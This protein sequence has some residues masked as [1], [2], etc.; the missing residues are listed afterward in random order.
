MSSLFI[1]HSE[2]FGE[3]VMLTESRPLFRNI[4]RN[5]CGQTQKLAE[6]S[7]LL[8]NATPVTSYIFPLA[9]SIHTIVVYTFQANFGPEVTF[10]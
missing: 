6:N 10:Y 7:Y 2:H 9:R 1:V 5:N 3:S 4:S 8:L